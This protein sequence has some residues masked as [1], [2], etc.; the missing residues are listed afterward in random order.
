MLCRHVERRRGC[1]THDL[2]IRADGR[3]SPHRMHV[4]SRVAVRPAC[5]KVLALSCSWARTAMFPLP[6]AQGEDKRV[7]L[8]DVDWGAVAD[9]VGT[10]NHA[11]CMERW[12]KCQVR[13]THYA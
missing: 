4:P 10:R 3:G 12:Y 5:C 2:V 7:V 13:L 6:S 1:S 9:K 11:Q 8:D